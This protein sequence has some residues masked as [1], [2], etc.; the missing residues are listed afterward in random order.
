M[1]V[2]DGGDQG[3]TSGTPHPCLD[4]APRLQPIFV[5]ILSIN[6][7]IRKTPNSNEP[8]KHGAI[9]LR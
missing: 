9:S 3:K 8:T 5:H 6:H 2:L 7:P 1:K 4:A